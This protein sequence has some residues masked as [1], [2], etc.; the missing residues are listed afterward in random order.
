MFILL[1]KEKIE[2]FFHKSLLLPVAFVGPTDAVGFSS[3]R[4]PRRGTV[5]RTGPPVWSGVHTVGRI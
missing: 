3:I 2:L 4:V 5:P 1:N